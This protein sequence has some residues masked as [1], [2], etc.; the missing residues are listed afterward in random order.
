MATARASPAE[1]AER[2]GTRRDALGPVTDA[3]RELSITPTSAEERQKE[4]REEVERE[5]SSHFT[6][7][8]L[9]LIGCGTAACPEPLSVCA[10]RSACRSTRALE[11]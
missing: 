8:L 3:V 11:E 9:A 6:P 10:A 2:G 7:P 1:G 5:V 4:K